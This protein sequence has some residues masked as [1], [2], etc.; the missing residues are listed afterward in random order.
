MPIQRPPKNKKSRLGITFDQPTPSALYFDADEKVEEKKTECTYYQ[1]L[2][3]FTMRVRLLSIVYW[4]LT[5]FVNTG[6]T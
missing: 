2:L 3:K 6:T 1:H 5:I 4:I